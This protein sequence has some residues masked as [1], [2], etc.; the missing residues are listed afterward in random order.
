M[1]KIINITSQ[2]FGRLTALRDAGKDKRGRVWLCLCDCGKEAMV[3]SSHLRTGHTRSCGCLAIEAA[4][5]PRNVKHGHTRIS[6]KTCAYEYHAWSS[7]K[8]RCF[9][10]NV[11]NYPRYGGRGITVCLRWQGDDGY[12]NF[13]ADMGMRP[14]KG[15]SIERNNTD[16]NYEPTNCRWATQTEQQNNRKGNRVIVWGEE[17]LTS[18]QWARKTG[19]SA[20]VIRGRIDSGWPVDDAL[21]K[22]I[23]NTSRRYG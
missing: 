12:A 15:Y 4:K 17:A 3:G 23:G 7:M 14:G 20:S 11:R 9:N 8:Q 2:K 19:L 1:P 21:T 22:P 18:A 10:P 5:I 16:G 6:S 13:I